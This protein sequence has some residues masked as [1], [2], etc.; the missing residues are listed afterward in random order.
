LRQEHARIGLFLANPPGLLVDRSAGLSAGQR[1][2]GNEA[3]RRESGRL[4]HLRRPAAPG[5]A[6]WCGAA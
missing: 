1:R 3:R 4:R 5:M 6:S 2:V